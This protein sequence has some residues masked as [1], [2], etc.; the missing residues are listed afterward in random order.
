MPENIVGERRRDCGLAMRPPPP[1]SIEEQ[2]ACFVVQS[3]LL[4]IILQTIRS[5]EI[6]LTPSK[7]AC[8]LLSCAMQHSDFRTACSQS[9]FQPSQESQFHSPKLEVGVSFHLRPGEGGVFVTSLD[10]VTSLE[11]ERSVFD[12]DETRIL[13]AAFEKAWTYVQF[14]PM[15]GVL[16][17]WERQSELARCLM[18]LLKLGYDNP[19]SLANSGIAL[20]RKI[21]KS[22]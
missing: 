14:D 17:A 13:S 3:R 6:R 19:V 5:T 12:S 8:F 20:L 21:Q 18:A 16:E 4:K 22:A 7:R 2:A 10:T 9:L 11:L 1:R 15:L